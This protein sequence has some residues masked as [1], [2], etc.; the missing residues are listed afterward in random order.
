MSNEKNVIM[1]DTVGIW[2]DKKECQIDGKIWHFVNLTKEWKTGLKASSGNIESLYFEYSDKGIKFYGSIAK[3]NKGTNLESISL[4]NTIN[5]IDKISSLINLDIMKYGKL[6]RIDINRNISTNRDV[7]DYL[8]YLGEKERYTR[9]E[10]SKNSILYKTRY[11]V[12]SFYDKK[13]EMQEKHNHHLL[14]TLLRYELR[15]INQINKQLG[16]PSNRVK[17]IL[18]KD[19][20]FKMIDI[21]LEEFKTIRKNREIHINMNQINTPKQAEE[22]IF[23]ELLRMQGDSF[24][25]N[26]LSDI[27]AGG[28]LIPQRRYELKKRLQKLLEK[29]YNDEYSL[30]NELETK[31]KEEASKAKG[32]V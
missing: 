7:A 32:M 12:L 20:Y 14:P 1:I 4:K 23:A 29:N 26:I 24:I 22:R 11:K 30:M 17:D 21:W 25:K 2:I 19:V 10:E 15:F 9:L 6:T 28:N 16:T 5:E 27:K 13:A 8:P 3:Q 31:I 18:T